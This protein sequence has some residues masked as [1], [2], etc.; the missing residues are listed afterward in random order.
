MLR[1]ASFTLPLKGND[2]HSLES[3][4]AR[5]RDILCDVF[6]GYTALPCQ[7]G[8]RDSNGTLLHE[9]NWLYN[10]AIPDEF[11]SRAT[12]RGIACYA[13]AL[14]KQEAMLVTFPGGDCEIVESTNFWADDQTR[15]MLQRD[16][17]S[18]RLAANSPWQ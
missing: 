2:G 5:I 3:E 12:F 6:G 9:A 16:R 1:I 4:H 11:E 18:A 8:W 14:A 13:G 10:V 17:T 7:G 15:R